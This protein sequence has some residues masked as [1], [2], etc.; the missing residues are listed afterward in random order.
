MYTQKSFVLKPADAEKNWYL[1]DASGQTVGRLATKIADVL[2]GKNSPKYTPHTDSGDYVVVINAEKVVFTGD[3]LD[4]K[5]YY[6]HSGYVGGLKERTAREQLDR[7]PT[8]VLM[9]AVKGML[10]K[11]SLGRKQL[12]KLKVFAGTEHTH[13]AQQPQ[14]LKL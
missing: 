14:E 3:K 1:V 6:R 7:Q 8:K 13:E 2:R 9:S 5:V 4:K 10:P 11:N 12:T